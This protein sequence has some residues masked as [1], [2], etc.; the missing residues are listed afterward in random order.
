MST[1]L[2]RK[3]RKKTKKGEGAGAKILASLSPSVY[4]SDRD[5]AARYRIT[6]ASIWRW[7]D[8]RALPKPIQFSPGCTR[9]RLSDLERWETQ[10]IGTTPPAA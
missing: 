4:L 5:L 8:T 9:W 3:R 2:V 10:K 6:R 7:I 1:T